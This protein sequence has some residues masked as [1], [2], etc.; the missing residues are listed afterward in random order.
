MTPLLWIICATLVGGLLSVALAAL[1][2][3]TLLARFVKHLVSFSVGALLAAAMLNLIPE[4]VEVGLHAHDLG[5]TL[6]VGLLVFFV[7]EKLALWRHSHAHGDDE[8]GHDHGHSHGHHH[9]HAHHADPHSKSAAFMIVVGDSVH[10][11]ADGVLL[12]AAFLQDVKLGLATTVAVVAHEVPQEV[13]DFMILLNSGMARKKALLLN[14]G[15]SLMAVVGGV[16]GYFVLSSLQPLVPYVL[17]FAAASFIYIA[18]ADLV[19][20]LHRHHKPS[21]A[22]LQLGLILLGVALV[23]LTSNHFGHTH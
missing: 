20:E 9:G 4:A 22:P 12:A 10:N 17:V 11:F 2:S 1:L 14:L 23:A 16:A 8:H 15:S 5:V 7:L 18:V 19:P 13:G 6:L 21:V 3:F